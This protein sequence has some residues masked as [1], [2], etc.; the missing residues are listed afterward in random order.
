MEPWKTKRFVF[1]AGDVYYASGGFADFRGSF[2][3]K[4]EAEVARDEWLKENNFL[5]WTQIGDLAT[6][7]YWARGQ[8]C[9][10][11]SIFR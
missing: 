3:T 8:A 9:A 1:M 7:D 11:L 4:E 10:P 5:T 6:G 2:D